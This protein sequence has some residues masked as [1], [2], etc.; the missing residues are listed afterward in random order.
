MNTLCI[1]PT[2]SRRRPSISQMSLLLFQ[3]Q[4]HL[5]I[6]LCQTK[7]NATQGSPIRTSGPHARANHMDHPPPRCC[8]RLIWLG[9]LS[10]INGCRSFPAKF[11][12]SR[13]RNSSIRSSSIRS[14][15]PSRGIRSR[16]SSIRNS[17]SSSIL[18]SCSSSCSRICKCSRCSSSYSSNCQR[19]IINPPPMPHGCV[20]SQGRTHASRLRTGRSPARVPRPT[21]RASSRCP[22]VPQ[23]VYSQLGK[24]DRTAQRRVR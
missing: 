21:N 8:P 16:C 2:T 11:K 15:I 4:C 5:L 7:C 23:L 17:C 19:S 3:E 22:R 1:L 12:C 24:A 14:S 10:I 20:G 18:S 13:S 9:S 6:I